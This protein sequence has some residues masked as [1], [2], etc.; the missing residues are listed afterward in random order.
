MLCGRYKN[1][2]DQLALKFS[3]H[4]TVMCFSHA[5]DKFRLEHVLANLLSNAIKFSSHGTCIMVHVSVEEEPTACKLPS[6]RK[7]HPTSH[8][9]PIIRFSSASI[10]LK[11]I[12]SRFGA[13]ITARDC[14]EDSERAHPAVGTV[15]P[16][17]DEANEA[18]LQA[19]L[20]APAVASTAI[21][22]IKIAVSDK[23]MGISAEAQKSLFGMFNQVNAGANQRGQV[24]Q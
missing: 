10:R 1:L 20:Q 21:R 4:L 5:P 18:P 16:V 8:T 11:E 23:G 19:P 22:R 6:V 2:N 3:L 12:T 7:S 13:L 9:D 14:G 15:E 24:R 17:A